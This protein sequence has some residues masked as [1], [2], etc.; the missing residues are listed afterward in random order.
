MLQLYIKPTIRIKYIYLLVYLGKYEHG[1]IA[2]K[3]CVN[4]LNNTTNNYNIEITD[5]NT[6]DS[7]KLKE[8]S[9][10]VE[11]GFKTAQ[12]HYLFVEL[13]IVKFNIVSA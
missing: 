5:E 9:N 6:T 2:E 12:L 3:D 11:S 1:D 4:I 8:D 7:L 10:H 13:N